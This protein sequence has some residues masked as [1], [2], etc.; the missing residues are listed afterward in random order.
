MLEQ[1][2]NANCYPPEQTCL[3]LRWLAQQMREHNLTVFHLEHLQPDW[4]ST[5]QQQ[6][7]AWFAVRLPAL[8]IGV[9]ISILVCLFFFS[10]P[11]NWP[12][13]LQYGVLGGL[14]GWL[15]QEAAVPTHTATSHFDWKKHLVTSVGVGLLYAGSYACYLS[16]SPDYTL[17]QWFIEGLSFGIGI[18]LGSF[19]LTALLVRPS[20]HRQSSQTRIPQQ[21]SRA[22][23]FLQALQLPR[24]ALVTVV[25]GL[26]LLL[27]NGL[28]QG[29]G[30]GMN[31]VINVISY[32]GFQTTLRNEVGL[33]LSNGLIY[34]L[35]Y[36]LI[37]LTLRVQ[38]EGVRLT[39]R[40]RWTPKSLGHSLFNMR[41]L[42]ITFL[43]I[44]T[45][46]VIWVLTA[47]LYYGATYNISDGISNGLVF[48]LSLGIS[49][50][51]IYWFFFGL[52]YGVAQE[53]LEDK[54]RRKVNQGITDSRNN[55]WKMSLTGGAMVGL[56]GLLIYPLSYG[57]S[58]LL[59]WKQFG[60]LAN[61]LTNGLENAWVNVIWIGL[62]GM[63]LIYFLAGGLAVLK[64]QV[65]C[66]LLARSRTFPWSAQAFLDDA[67]DRSFLQHVGG[68]Y[69]FFHQLLREHFADS[70]F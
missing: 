62:F 28:S 63:L 16:N 27:G 22:F 24:A 49:L 35:S 51:L 25:L 44:F 66:L 47:V 41:H 14:L 21:W 33:V 39:E 23:R 50:G 58:Y 31:D 18:G 30:Y 32:Y 61:E 17:H 42:G 1:R 67:T 36:G 48:G 7:Y 4:L 53:Q 56:L 68:G 13:F 64:H 40:L 46:A 29:F 57:M 59:S 12:N 20:H 10:V 5:R 65:I 45:L 9:L 6:H 8:I 60:G 43:L 70:E 19:L 37:S 11:L 55:G 2:G 26:A 15:W 3:W 69:R 34:G 52:F 38:T 54:E